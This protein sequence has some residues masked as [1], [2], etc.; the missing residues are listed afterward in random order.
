MNSITLQ[1]REIL[2]DDIRTRAR[3]YEL[4]SRMGEYDECI[5]NFEG[6]NFISRSFAD[7]LIS[8][9]EGSSHH[10]DFIKLNDEINTLLKIVKKGRNTKHE[11]VSDGN[12][13]Y[14]KTM[15]ELE[16]FFSMI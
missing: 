11:F 9:K 5:L 1:V 8:M 6:V 10:I 14:L 3:I 16:A 15:G 4:T 13:M 7:E 12:I 2:G